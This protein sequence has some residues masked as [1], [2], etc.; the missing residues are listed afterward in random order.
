MWAPQ[1]RSKGGRQAP[2]SSSTGRRARA[3]TSSLRVEVGPEEADALVL[4]EWQK[5]AG[6]KARLVDTNL[7]TEVMKAFF[8]K[9]HPVS[10]FVTNRRERLA[11]EVEKMLTE[12]QG[13]PPP[14][15]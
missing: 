4:T 12:W 3:R 5:A 7:T 6:N 8:R 1:C 9:R 10:N 2:A 11:S 15:K 14:R 13:I